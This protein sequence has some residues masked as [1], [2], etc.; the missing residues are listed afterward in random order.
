MVNA[1]INVAQ[2]EAQA[3]AQAAAA[4]QQQQ[5]QQYG[6]PPGGSPPGYGAPPGAPPQYG[7]P[8]QQSYGQPPQSPYGQPPQQAYG[9]QPPAQAYGQAPPAYGQPAP[10]AAFGQPQAPYGQPPG[11]AGAP[12]YGQPGAP[13]P[14]P[15]M[16]A[17]QIGIGG[18]GPGGIPRIN[19]SGGDFSPTKIV[20]VIVKGDGYESPRR[21]GALFIGAAMAFYIVNTVLIFALHLYYPYFYSLGAI[22]WWAGWWL[23]IFGQPRKTTDGSPSAMWGRIG[24]AVCLAFG[25]LSALGT[26]FS[27]RMA[28]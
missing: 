21:M 1:P 24:L 7:Q 17:P 26:A 20:N 14:Q 19:F 5:Q 16:Q 8:P 10:Q 4:A 25:A 27:M 23:L 11:Y 3:R 2:F 15:G 22:I 28:F 6:Q 12:G 13:Q 18:F 9:Q